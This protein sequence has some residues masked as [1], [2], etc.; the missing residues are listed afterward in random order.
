MKECFDDFEMQFNNWLAEQVLEALAGEQALV[1]IVPP[2]TSS[3]WMNTD[4]SC[5]VVKK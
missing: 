4:N 1:T 2:T 5:V 3:V